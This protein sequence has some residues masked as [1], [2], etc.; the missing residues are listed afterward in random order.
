MYYKMSDSIKSDKTNNM[1]EHFSSIASQYHNLR[2]TDLEPISYMIERLNSLPNIK[3]VDVGCGDGRYDRILCRELGDKFNLTCLDVNA[4]MLEV[5]HRNLIADGLKNFTLI[6]SNAEDLSLPDNSYD[7]IFTFNAVH[8]FD[9]L[10]F[11]HQ[12]ARI[13]KIGGYLFIYTRL[14]DQ[15]KRNIWGSFFPGF[16][17]K[18]IRLCSLNKMTRTMNKVAGIRVQ[19]IEYFKYSRL[20]SLPELEKKIR[21]HHYSTFLLYPVDELEKAID[22]FKKKIT[23][24]YEDVNRILW[25]DENILFV[26]RKGNET[27]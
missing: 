6:Q 20:S 14:R 12:S 16:H 17:Q 24:V 26:I 21:S 2:I 25:Y 19:S 13:L 3:A 15:N 10:R 9:L 11:L 8:H 4:H 27:F 5:L 7:C 18:E 22:M 23:E 1:N